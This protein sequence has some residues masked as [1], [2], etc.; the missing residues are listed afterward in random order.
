MYKLMF[1]GQEV[2]TTKS[3][4][5]AFCKIAALEQ[6]QSIMEL[7]SKADVM[8]NLYMA[9][10]ERDEVKILKYSQWANEMERVNAEYVLVKCN[11]LFVALNPGMEVG[12]ANYLLYLF[13]A[14]GF[15]I[16]G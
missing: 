4:V 10:Q 14:E 1:K 5:Q 9:Q 8:A 3:L 15:I 13:E 12:M 2:A 11:G 7:H 6:S 16:V